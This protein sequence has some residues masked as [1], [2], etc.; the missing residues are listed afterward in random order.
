MSPDVWHWWL[1]LAS[2][3]GIAVLAIP[4]WSLNQRKKK[5]QEIRDALPREAA[6]FKDHVK[7]ILKDKRNREVSDWS[8]VDERCLVIGYLLLLGSSVIRLFIP[9]A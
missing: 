4:V 6:T 7:T 9:V 1:N 3:A 2:T 8:P 5:L